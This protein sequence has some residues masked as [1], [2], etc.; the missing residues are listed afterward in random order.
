MA[1]VGHPPAPVTAVITQPVRPEC[2]VQFRAWQEELNRAVASFVGFLGTEVMEPADDGGE[3]T[4]IYRFDSVLS[5][6]SW[7]TSPARQQRLERGA[8]LFSAPLQQRVVLDKHDEDLVTV[9]VTHHVHGGRE[10]EFRAF[11]RTMTDAERAFPGFRGADLF[12]PVPPVQSDWTAMYRFDSAT[13]L[14]AW[15]QSP[16]RAELLAANEEFQD[17]DLHRVSSSFGSWFSVS[18]Q[19]TDDGGPAKWKTALSVLVGLY[20]TVVLLTVCISELWPGADLWWSLLLGN[21]LSVSLLTW[22]VMPVV[23]R[24]LRFWLEPDPRAPLARLG[25]VGAAA[26]IAFLTAAATVFCLVTTV[27]WKLP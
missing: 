1:V 5:L 22:V 4:I 18:D 14:D 19:R 9:V 15:L 24:A 12:P 26:S 21:V 3:W 10:E 7:L 25:A 6:E 8:G 16:R 27:I 2:T 23:T 17:F 13:H 11:Q 20:P